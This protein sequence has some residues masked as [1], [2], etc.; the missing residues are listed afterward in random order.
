MGLHSFARLFPHCHRHT[1]GSAA[2]AGLVQH[3]GTGTSLAASA[4][5]RPFLHLQ[6]PAV[7]HQ[8]GVPWHT[9]A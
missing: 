2:L 5:F 6:Q 7:L 3:R 1:P 8:D 4:G 9:V